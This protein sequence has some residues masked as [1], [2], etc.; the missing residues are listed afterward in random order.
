MSKK[1]GFT[2][3]ELMVVITIIGILAAA[4]LP[5]LIKSQEAANQAADQGNLKW[6]YQ[7]MT[8]YK[9]KY[10]QRS[11][12]EGGHKFVLDTW[13]R[14]VVEHT[15]QNVDR[16]FSVQ[17][18][19]SDPVYRELKDQDP[20]TIWKSLDELTSYDTHWAGRAKEHKRGMW[21]GKEIIMAT[22]NEGLN[23]YPDGSVVVLFGDG[24]TKVLNRALDF[25]E[26]GYSE[27]P[28]EDELI[29]VGP[30]SMHPGLQ[31]LDR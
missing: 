20:E 19:G 10:E 6:H 13:V 21:S 7:V 18:R 28:D 23:I 16:Y 15:E 30:Q 14:G 5:E 11:P 4:L 9:N 8:L 17:D 3:I 24:A 25:A 29:E 2:L 22:D 26:F 27:D 1:S 12:R 31:K